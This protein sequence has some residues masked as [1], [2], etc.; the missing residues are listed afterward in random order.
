MSLV[1]KGFDSKLVPHDFVPPTILLGP[2]LHFIRFI[3]QS[4]LTLPFRTQQCLL[5]DKGMLNLGC[6]RTQEKGAVTLQETDPDLP[7][8]VRESQA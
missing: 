3:S 1:D 7:V 2:L 4:C 5:G 6:T 8:S